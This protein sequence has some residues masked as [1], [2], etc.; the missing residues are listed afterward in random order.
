MPKPIQCILLIDDDPDD[1]FFHRLVIEES[2]LCETV[3]VAENGVD[4]LNYL[5]QPEHPDYQRPDVILLDINMPV[6]NG[7][8]FLEAYHQLP[9]S[10]K[11][12]VLMLMLTTSLDHLDWQRANALAEV[13]AY[14]P[15]PLTKAMLHEL[16]DQYFA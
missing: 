16:A 4:A 9:D 14:K 8:E 12:R 5:T 11:S 6:M 7:F 15:K 1:N 2:G 3:R 10:L 13:S